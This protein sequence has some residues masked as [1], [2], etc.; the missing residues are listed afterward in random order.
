MRLEWGP[1]IT[2][3]RWDKLEEIAKKKPTQQL[4][5]TVA[6]LALGLT[7]R[8]DKRPLKRILFILRLAGFTPNDPD[9]SSPESAKPQRL[10]FAYMSTAQRHGYIEFIYGAPD[11]VKYRYMFVLLHERWGFLTVRQGEFPRKLLPIKHQ[12]IVETCPFPIV[13]VNPDFCLS[14]IAKG[15]ANRKRGEIF[16]PNGFWKRAFAA[17]IE[18][19]HPSVRLPDA[20]MDSVGRTAHLVQHP[21]AS[22]WR[23]ALHPMEAIWTTFHAIRWGDATDKVPLLE[24]AMLDARA[25]L[26]TPEVILEHATRLRD[27]AYF[28]SVR[29]ENDSSKKTLAVA[30]NLEMRGPESDYFQQLCRWT[31]SDLDLEVEED[32]FDVPPPSRPM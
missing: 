2:Q 28:E 4:C 17:A 24:R 18:V 5:D 30:L 26:C 32:E 14:R 12:Y 8:E 15:L 11:G 23:L 27:L 25:E 31:A 7:A 1:I 21:I 13:Q 6:E 9:S 29:G 22:E 19:E 20:L 3:K 16:Y 10:E